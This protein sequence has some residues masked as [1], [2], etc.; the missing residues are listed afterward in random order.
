[1]VVLKRVSN[2][3][4]GRFTTLMIPPSLELH[5]PFS[6]FRVQ[7]SPAPLFVCFFFFWEFHNFMPPSAVFQLPDETRRALFDFMSG[8]PIKAGGSAPGHV[9][10]LDLMTLAP[11]H[12]CKGY[13]TFRKREGERESGREREVKQGWGKGWE[14]GVT[15]LIT[16]WFF[17][18][19]NGTKQPGRIKWPVACS[20]LCINRKGAQEIPE[21]N[22]QTKKG[23]KSD[24]R[25]PCELRKP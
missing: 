4:L 15:L 20:F 17:F 12:G 7:F 5:E 11:A 13:L 9:P 10:L 25:C 14:V 16:I 24:M 23:R 3:V 18:R 2:M 22:T 6:Q 8:L 21:T 1:M 19:Y